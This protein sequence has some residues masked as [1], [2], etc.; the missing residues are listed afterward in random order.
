VGI[1]VADLDIPLSFVFSSNGRQCMMFK[2]KRQF[3]VKLLPKLSNP[4][5][6]HANSIGH[7]MNNST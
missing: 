6:N 7:S 2:A 4:L 3:D 5:Q 1:F